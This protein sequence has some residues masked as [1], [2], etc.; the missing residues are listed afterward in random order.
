[1]Q[2]M[3]IVVPGWTGAAVRFVL[4]FRPQGFPTDVCVPISRLADCIMAS[5]EDVRAAGACMGV[6][7]CAG[8]LVGWQLLVHVAGVTRGRCDIPYEP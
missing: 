8:Q 2:L 1:M 4:A 7:K 6:G 3:Q 5:Q